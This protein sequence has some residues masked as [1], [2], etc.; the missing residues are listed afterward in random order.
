MRLHII[1]MICRNGFKVQHF[2]GL[3]LSLKIRKIN[4]HNYYLLKYMLYVSILL[5][6]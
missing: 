4:T 3:I 2:S 1:I 6:E 5:F